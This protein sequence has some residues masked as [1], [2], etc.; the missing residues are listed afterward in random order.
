MS[1]YGTHALLS[2]GRIVFAGWNGETVPT[3]SEDFRCG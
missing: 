3:V 2:R 1:G